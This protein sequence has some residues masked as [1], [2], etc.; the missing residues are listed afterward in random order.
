MSLIFFGFPGAGK[1]YF[2][3]L[4]AEKVRCPFVD[5]DELL[6]EG[7]SGR[8]LFKTLGEKDFRK[9]ERQA[10]FRLHPAVDSVIA[11]GGGTV[12]D[13][14]NVSL[15]QTLGHFVYLHAGFETIQKK[16][17][18]HDLTTFV[19]EENPVE[20]LKVLYQERLPIFEAIP[21]KKV[22]I[23][24]LNEAGV[25]ASLRAIWDETHTLKHPPSHR[26]F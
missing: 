1:T 8:E 6:A 20:S 21:A 24:H 12:L 17:I 14:Q 18:E 10:L 11:L 16:M 15:L 3:K 4:L 5:L 13:P 2:G 25:I 9:L 26:S 23:D 19:T 7:R 22:S